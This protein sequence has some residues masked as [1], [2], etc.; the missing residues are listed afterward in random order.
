MHKGDYLLISTFSV[1]FMFITDWAHSGSECAMG[2]GPVTT[3]D[4][5]H[6]AVQ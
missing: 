6:I 3:C 5:I 4:T 1:A 2:R